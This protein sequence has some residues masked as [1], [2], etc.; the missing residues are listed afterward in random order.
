MPDERPRNSEGPPLMADEVQDS[1]AP[2]DRSQETTL[3]QLAGILL[4]VG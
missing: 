3:E 1:S 4:V 2:L